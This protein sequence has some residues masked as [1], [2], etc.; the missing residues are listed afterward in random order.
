MNWGTIPDWLTFAATAVTA[1]V[2]WKALSSWK[3]QLEGQTQHNVAIEVASAARALRYAFY[4]A[5]SPLLLASEFP[6][7]YQER[8][9]GE[10]PTRSQEA[11]EHAF[12]YQSRLKALWPYITECAKLRPKAGITFGDGCADALESLA[13]K[14]RELEFIAQDYVEQMSVG[15][16]IVTQWADQSWVKRVKTSIRVGSDRQDPLSLEFEAAM[17]KVFDEIDFPYSPKP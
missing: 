10:K 12:V 14:A 7:S 4:D 1:G 6:E 17:K 16:E 2:A 9:M 3:K 8:R 15:Q 13:K 5:R 11:Q